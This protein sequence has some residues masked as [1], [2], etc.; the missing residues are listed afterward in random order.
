MK[1]HNALLATRQRGASRRRPGGFDIEAMG[2]SV[3]RL[4]VAV[5][6]Q[7]A[8]DARAEARDLSRRYY[9]LHAFAPGAIGFW[10]DMAGVDKGRYTALFEAQCL[11][12]IARARAATPR[13]PRGR[14]KATPPCN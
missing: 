6:H 3:A 4:A 8:L 11:A 5:L 12:A 7:A 14:P 1:L 10:C 9:T 13:R 2:D